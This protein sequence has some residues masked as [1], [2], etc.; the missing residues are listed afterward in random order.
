MSERTQIKILNAAVT[1]PVLVEAVLIDGVTLTEAQTADA[2]WVSAMDLLCQEAALK[3]IPEDEWPVHTHWRWSELVSR[4][5][6]TSR[7]LGIECQGEMQ[8]MIWLH[9]D[10][11]T[12][13]PFKQGSPLIYVE[14]VAIAPWNYE[15]FLTKLGQKA[16][17]RRCGS[18]FIRAA[19]QASIESGCEGRLGLHSLP[20]AEEFYRNV[21]KMEDMGI[22][23][24]HEG[25][26]YFEMTSVQARAF[27]GKQ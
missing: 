11:V 5:T 23:P 17:F 15:Q 2:S 19:I 21:C 7:F 4:A 6:S 13:R 10:E 18:V 27:A 14:R 8:G 22:D 26:H 24:V 12:R 25:L 1:P 20:D 16:R 3:G 9:R